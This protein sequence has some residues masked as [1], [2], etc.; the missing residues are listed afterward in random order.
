GNRLLERRIERLRLS[1]EYVFLQQ[2]R[3]Y[4]I[5]PHGIFSDEGNGRWKINDRMEKRVALFTQ[6]AI[7]NNV[8]E[9]SEGGLTPEQYQLEWDSIFNKGAKTNLALN[10]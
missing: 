2:S 7:A 3:F 9:L 8:R 5:E 6:H 4:G 1:Q 10:A